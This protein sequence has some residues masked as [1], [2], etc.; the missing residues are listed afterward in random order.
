[1]GVRATEHPIQLFLPKGTTIYFSDKLLD[2]TPERTANDCIVIAY[3]HKSSG[4]WSAI[5]HSRGVTGYPYN[6]YFLW[7][8]GCIKVKEIKT[9]LS[10]DEINSQVTRM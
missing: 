10:S 8:E 2:S 9:S 5:A 4:K 3:R 6:V 1:M 7:R